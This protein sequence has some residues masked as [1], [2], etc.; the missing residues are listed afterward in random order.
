MIARSSLFQIIWYQ[1]LTVSFMNFLDVTI[2]IGY[3]KM[4]NPI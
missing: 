4:L 3:F 1:K 2:I